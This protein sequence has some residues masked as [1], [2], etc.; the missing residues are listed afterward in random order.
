ME[1]LKKIISNGVDPKIEKQGLL[2]IDYLI[3]KPLPSLEVFR[4]ISEMTPVF[5]MKEMFR[6][7][8]EKNNFDGNFLDIFEK[9]IG[10]LYFENIDN[11]T[12]LHSAIKSGNKRLVNIMIEQGE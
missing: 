1:D 12:P 9:R 8:M 10:T 7:F 2:P 6:L 3:K 5:K 11:D 4:V